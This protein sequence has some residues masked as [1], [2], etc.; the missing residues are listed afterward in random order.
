MV[1]CRGILAALLGLAASRAMAADAALSCQQHFNDERYALAAQSCSIA[2]RAGD[3][4]AQ[5]MLGEM[6]DEGLGVEVSP[7]QAKTWWQAA[8]AQSYLPAQN[9]LALKYYYGGDVFGPQPGWT[10]DYQQAYQLWSSSATKGAET[11]QFMLGEMYMR[12]QGVAVDYAEAYAWFH[13]ALSDG[14]KLATDSLVELTR[15]MSP[16]QKRNG[17]ARLLEL[18]QTIP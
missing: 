15:L 18:Q 6:Y 4:S 5:T 11:S 3:A 16:T 14:Y 2:A 7:L 13:L 9:L 8:S 1:D 10:Q 12:G 17:Q